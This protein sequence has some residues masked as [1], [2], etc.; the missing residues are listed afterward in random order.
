[1]PRADGELSLRDYLNVG[2]VQGI[3]SLLDEECLIPKGTEEA[4]VIK[5]NQT[6]AN[7]PLYSEPTLKRGEMIQGILATD[8][9]KTKISFAIRFGLIALPCRRLIVVEVLAGYLSTLV[10][11]T[12][13][14][15]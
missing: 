7:N 5:M 1:M 14:A 13:R 10:A 6:F 2:V 4:Y 8:N 9:P 15:M 3:F 12:M 11:G